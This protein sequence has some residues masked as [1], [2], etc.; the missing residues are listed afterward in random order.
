MLAAAPFLLS[1]ALASGQDGQRCCMGQEGQRCGMGQMKGPR[2]GMAAD[3]AHAVDMQLF[4]FLLD[5]RAEIRRSVT[6]LPDGVE[7]LT[8]S[9]V[10]ETAS[11]IREHVRSMYARLQESRPI[12]ARDPLFAETFRHADKIEMTM[13]ETEGGLRVKEISADPYVAKLIKSHAEVVSRFLAEGY[14][15]MRKNH[16]VPERD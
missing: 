2:R 11:R 9:D 14:A 16:P 7:T 1:A 8:E 4:H 6:E 13:V 10:P 12:H 15:E 5:H 3:D